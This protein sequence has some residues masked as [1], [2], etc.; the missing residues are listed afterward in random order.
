M[1]LRSASAADTIVEI[2]GTKHHDIKNEQ[3][4]AREIILRSIAVRR[5]QPQFRSKLMKAYRG[6]CAVT[7]T[8]EKSVLEAAHI[9]PYN[10]LKTNNVR[11]GILL[12]A[13]IHTLFDLGLLR[14]N[15]HTLEITVA[16]KIKDSSYRRYH[17]N[18]LTIPAN[19]EER[20]SMEALTTRFSSTTGDN[21][22]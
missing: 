8:S 19:V 17:G 14:I 16:S 10:G 7:G 6:A 2:I 9:V 1:G 13:D 20:P 12:R 18:T 4:D 15:P 5:G 11:N 3:A 22:G 21:E